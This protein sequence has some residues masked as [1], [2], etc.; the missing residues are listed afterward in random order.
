MAILGLV[1]NTTGQGVE[2][3]AEGDARL[4]NART[5][6]AHAASH[7]TGQADALTP[8][9]IGA[10]ASNDGRL[11]DARTPTAHAASHAT[12][13]SDALTPSAIGAA[14]AGDLSN[15][16]GATTGAHGGIVASNDARLSDARTPTAHDH[17]ALDGQ[18]EYCQGLFYN[19]NDGNKLYKRAWRFTVTKGIITAV[20]SLG[21]Y[22]INNETP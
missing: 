5:P 16:T 12:G 11:S 18:F 3:V 1:N 15:H 21:A 10:C 20:E 14:A 6:T 4:T 8:G 22:Q 13:Q 7:A 9:A 2:G 19:T 17:G